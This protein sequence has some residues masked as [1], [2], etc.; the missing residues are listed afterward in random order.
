[1]ITMKKANFSGVD[2]LVVG[3]LGC[4]EIVELGIIA[5]NINGGFRFYS[6]NWGGAVVD[7]R[8]A[9][10]S[11]ARYDSVLDAR[12]EVSAALEY[13]AE[14]DELSADDL[15]GSPVPRDVVWF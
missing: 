9:N 12:A 3:V 5:K 10:L 7:S 2:C 15:G 6:K 14:M 13:A 8:I 1:M 4:K 11:G